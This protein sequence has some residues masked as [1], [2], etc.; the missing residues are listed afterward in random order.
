MLQLA[1][2][3]VHKTV[4]IKLILDETFL[5]LCFSTGGPGTTDDGSLI[6]S[7]PEDMRG[8]VGFSYIT[9]ITKY[10]DFK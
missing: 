7:F 1:V 8:L 9:R 4:I 5:D 6:L 10:D 3:L 2:L